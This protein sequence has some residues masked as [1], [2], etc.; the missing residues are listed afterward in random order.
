MYFIILLDLIIPLLILKIIMLFPLK[1]EI[2]IDY[3]KRELTII[4]NLKYCIYYF[5]YLLFMYYSCNL[6]S[7]SYNSIYS[8]HVNYYSIYYAF[9]LINIILIF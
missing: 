4:D 8:I 6:Y 2:I 5:L 3:K 1:S 9:S 7:I